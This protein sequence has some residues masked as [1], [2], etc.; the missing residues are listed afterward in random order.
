MWTRDTLIRPSTKRSGEKIRARFG[1]GEEDVV[2]DVQRPPVG[3]GEGGRQK[4][5]EAFLQV[6]DPGLKL[7]LVGS[8]WYGANGKTPLSLICR[9]FAEKAPD[10]VFQT[11]FIPFAEMPAYYAAADICVLPSLLEEAAPLTVLRPWPPGKPL[12]GTDAG[13]I[14]ENVSEDCAVIVKRDENFVPS[15]PRH[16]NAQRRPGAALPDGG[17]GPETDGNAGCR[18]LLRAFPANTD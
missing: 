5:M 9:A 8:D 10:R 4:L 12:I 11:G 13:G 3:R 18:K 17:D 15:W 7:L 2:F 1:V 14:V 6:P 16:R